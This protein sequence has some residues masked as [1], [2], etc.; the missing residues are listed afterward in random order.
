MP[1]GQDRCVPAIVLDFCYKS[2]TWKEGTEM[3]T[4]KIYTMQRFQFISGIF[5]GTQ[6]IIWS[7]VLNSSDSSAAWEWLRRVTPES[8]QRVRFALDHLLVPRKPT[9]CITDYTHSTWNSPRNHRHHKSHT[10]KLP[11]PFKVL[12][13]RNTAERE[14]HISKSKRH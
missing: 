11:V 10:Q 1:G 14:V 9:Q 7:L 5:G 4:L 12:R 6:D 8:A 3:T 13:Q 2:V